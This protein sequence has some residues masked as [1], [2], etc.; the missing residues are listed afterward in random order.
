MAPVDGQMYT[1]LSNSN[2]S[3]G[4]VWGNLISGKDDGRET[5]VKGR[6]H[7]LGGS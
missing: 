4:L 7:D 6:I 2:R 5:Q 1:R 3:A